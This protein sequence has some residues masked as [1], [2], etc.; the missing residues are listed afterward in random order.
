MRCLLL[1]QLCGL[2][3]PPLALATGPS[4]QL[5][6]S[7]IQ[8]VTVYAN[9]AEVWRVAEL[10]L[11]P[12]TYRLGFDQLSARLMPQSVRARGEGSGTGILLGLTTAQ[13]YLHPPTARMQLLADSLKWLR[14]QLGSLANRK[15]SLQAEQRLIDQNNNLNGELGLDVPALQQ[16]LAW[17]R[18]RTAQILEQLRNIGR[19]EQTYRE[20]ATRLERQLGADL[21]AQRRSTY[22]VW[23]DFQVSQGGTFRFQLSYLVDQA[24]W[25]PRYDLRA[26]S[27]QSGVLLE[28]KADVWNQTE[29]DWKG[30]QL[31][32]NTARPGLGTQAPTFASWYLRAAQP[33]YEPLHGAR[34]QAAADQA[35]T[36][37]YADPTGLETR[38]NQLSKT[39]VLKAKQDVPAD[40]QPRTLALESQA[41]PAT[42]VHY[43][44]PKLE[45]SVFLQA[46]VTG[47]EQYELLAG[48]ANV[49]MD[50]A[51]VAESYIDPGQT[52]DTLRLDLGR[53]PRVLIERREDPDFT[54]RKTIG[55]YTRIQKQYTITVRNTRAQAVRILIEDQLPLS[56]TDEVEVSLLKAEGATHQVQDGRL[57]WYLNLAAGE[58]RELTFSFEVK[59]KKNLNLQGL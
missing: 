5:L 31:E 37:A 47:W 34:K 17:Q 1:F 29:E 45:Q 35:A 52:E 13:D 9:Q 59:H 58:K 49:Y 40:G 48:A 51:F 55:A 21:E 46:A 8:Q 10:R 24:G 3:L 14:R 36:M 57:S 27:G 26:Q 20:T 28:M 19:E 33:V 53:D 42:L 12:G 6:S 32:L 4:D 16:L 7:R 41:L 18:I 54:T 11:A 22:T 44:A 50:Q 23:V 30:V 2:L 38:Q 39:Y 56:H 25:K 43:A 15:T